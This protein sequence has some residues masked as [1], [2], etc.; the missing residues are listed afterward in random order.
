MDLEY[1]IAAAYHTREKILNSPRS[2]FQ[3]DEL[4]EIVNLQLRKNCQIIQ[5]INLGKNLILLQRKNC[6]KLSN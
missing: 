5:I 4:Q 6:Q 2:L 1:L 3:I